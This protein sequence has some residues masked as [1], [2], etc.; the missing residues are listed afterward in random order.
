[1]QGHPHPAAL[2]RNAAGSLGLDLQL[3]SRA[4][5]LVLAQ[6]ALGCSLNGFVT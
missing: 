6:A 5:E 4:F 1:M 3:L 2:G